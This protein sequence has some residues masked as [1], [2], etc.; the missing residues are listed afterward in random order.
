VQLPIRDRRFHGRLCSA[1]IREQ[2][3]QRI[4]FERRRLFAR[5]PRG[6]TFQ[7]LP[8]RVQLK[9]LCLR[10]L[11]DDQT[12]RLIE[13]DQPLRLESFERFSHR[14]A[15]YAQLIGDLGFAKTLAGQESASADG[16]TQLRIDELA[17]GCVGAGSVVP[18]GGAPGVG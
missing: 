13:R 8:H 5:K 15:A 14:R 7:H 4:Q 16:G 18:C 3:L 1:L 12:A 6:R 17:T 2:M 9:D 11:V 10:E